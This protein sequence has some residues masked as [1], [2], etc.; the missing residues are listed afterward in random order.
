MLGV[1]KKVTDL[2]RASAKN[3]A[4]INRKESLNYSLIVTLKIDA[5]FVGIGTLTV[6]IFILKVTICL[7]LQTR[8]FRFWPKLE[9]RCFGESPQGQT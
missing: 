3:L 4:R 1:P 9:R 8:A 5:L 6:Y 2:T 7:N